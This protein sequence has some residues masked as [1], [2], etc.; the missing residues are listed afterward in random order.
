[1][2]N[3]ILAA[4]FNAV[5]VSASLGL[6]SASLGLV[7]GCSWF[8]ADASGKEKFAWRLVW[9]DDFSG[10]SIN[11]K[12]W[13]FEKN[14]AGGGNNELQCYT[15][16]ANNAYVSNGALHIMARKEPVSGPA[17]FDDQPDYDAADTS[18]TRAYSSARLRTKHKGDWR[19]GRI[20]VRAKLPEGQGLWPAIWMLPSDSVYGRWP[21]SG[22]IDIMEAINSNTPAQ[23]NKI[24]GTLHYGDAPPG[25]K[26]I[27]IDFTP[28]TS[29]VSD[30]HTY[31]I[32]WEAGEIRFYVDDVHYATQISD[33]WYTAASQVPAAPFDQPFH[34]ILNVAVGGNWP[35]N[36]DASSQFPQQ[37]SVDFVRVYQCASGRTDGKGC[38]S[39]VNPLIKPLAE[40]RPLN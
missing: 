28:A 19:Y 39:H 14:C 30:Y 27:G 33:G 7:A 21:L 32:E 1:M 25:N 13:S 26:H 5:L 31:A 22:E 34:L 3:N 17:K 37:M 20:E 35:G 4:V 2:N 16:S 10:N 38:A 6:V 11:R 9:S 8:H 40:R 29:V 12:K 23:G 24:Y 18:A 15:D 36:P